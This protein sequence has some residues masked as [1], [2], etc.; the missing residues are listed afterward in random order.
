MKKLKRLLIIPARGGSKRI[1]NKN[2]KKF[3]NRPIIFYTINNAL[4]SKLFNKIHVS[5]DSNLVKKIVR[6]KK[7]KIDFMRPKKLSD[8]KTPLFDV[9]RFVVSQYKKRGLLFDEIWTIM[10]C[11]PNL[12]ME[13]LKKIST[14]YAK[15]RV[16]K[17]VLSV[18]EYKVPI[19]WAFNME[20]SGKLVSINRKFQ[21]IRSQDIKKK[22]FDAGQFCIYPGKKF[23]K[24]NFVKK[25]Y[26]Y[27]GYKLPA[28]KSIDIDDIEDWKLAEKLF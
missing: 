24:L 12:K 21:L 8:N 7:I 5:T 11:A 28:Q 10:P 27:I 17:P 19:E 14:F 1:K 18:S 4:K 15:Q 16:K 25:N 26:Y 9:Y 3:K 20:K 2:I 6:K 22:Y 23:L 13:D